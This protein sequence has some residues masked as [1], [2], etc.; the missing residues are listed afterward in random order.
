MTNLYYNYYCRIPSTVHQKVMVRVVNVMT[1]FVT[2]L[3]AITV[4]TVLIL[5]HLGTGIDPTNRKTPMY[6][7]SVKRRERIETTK[8]P[9]EI[10][11]QVSSIKHPDV[12]FPVVYSVV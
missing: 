11:I 8:P 2:P 4:Q 1:E 6:R 10:S 7:K 9:P 5:S 3:M 12:F